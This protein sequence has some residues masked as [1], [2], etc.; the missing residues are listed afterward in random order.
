M[1]DDLHVLG[2][3]GRLLAMLLSLESREQVIEVLKKGPRDEGT[4]QCKEV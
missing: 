1:E 2:H 3:L 4:E